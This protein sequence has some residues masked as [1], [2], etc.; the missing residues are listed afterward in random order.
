MFISAGL[1]IRNNMV[2]INITV[3]SYTKKNGTNVWTVN[4]CYGHFGKLEEDA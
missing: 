1:L 2:Y 3:F 4:Y